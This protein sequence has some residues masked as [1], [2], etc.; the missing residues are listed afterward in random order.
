[1]NSKIK[2]L[3]CNLIGIIVWAVSTVL[4]LIGMYYHEPWFDEAQAYLIARDASLHDILFV[5]PH[6]EGHPPFWHLII[7]SAVQLGLPSDLTLKV[8]QFI[9]FEAAIIML[10]FRS[11][12]GNIAKSV[13]PLSYFVLYQ[14]SVISRPYAMFMLAVLLCVSFYN[15]R[16]QKP[17]KFTLSLLFMCVCHSYGI[18]FAGGIVAADIL[19]KFLSE[20][21]NL[22]RTIV[23]FNKTLLVSYGLLFISAV[24]LI[25]EIMPAGDAYAVNGEDN[26]GYISA[27]L[28]CWTF[29]PSETLVTAFSRDNHCM[30]ENIISISDF[31]TA[32]IVSAA[33]WCCLIIICKRRKII[34]EMFIPYLFVSII[35]AL[36][37]SPH[38]YGLF[39]IYFIFILWIATSKEQIKFNE[40]SSI[41]IRKNFSE[42]FCKRFVYVITGFTVGVNVYW[43]ISSYICDI[44]YSYDQGKSV[45]EWIDSNNLS[46]KNI[47]AAWSDENT[48]IMTMGVI[49]TNFYFDKNI[50]FN[51][52]QGKTYL[53]HRMA[54]DK[55]CLDDIAEWKDYGEPDLILS[56]SVIITPEKQALGIESKYEMVYLGQSRRSFKNDQITGNIVIYARKDLAEQIEKN[57]Y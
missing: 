14:Y 39:Y 53:T 55:E 13:L 25:I 29:I 33:I 30:Q 45:A 20:Q 6:Y 8:I 50:F 23:N 27:F 54:D 48:N 42:K 26:Y 3:R 11:P 47:L 57:V 36:Y 56:T 15:E 22:K 49:T 18:A 31:I 46:D 40:F 37:V 5:I 19:G 32:S 35:M 21:K 1:M 52:D 12:F 9:F 51:T 43:S 41:L 24:L 34:K 28:F 4:V 10:E 16:D 7:R 38:H 2:W 17:I 44:K